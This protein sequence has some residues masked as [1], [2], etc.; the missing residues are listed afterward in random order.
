MKSLSSTQIEK[1]RKQ[2]VKFATL[3]LADKDLAEDVVQDAL[4][5]AYKHSA[6]FRREAALKTWIFAILKNKILDLLRTRKRHI[7]VSSLCE[8]EESPSAFF[9]RQ[10][11]WLE[12]QEVTEWRG[13]AQSTYRKE[14]WAIFDICLNKLSA[15]QARVFMMREH[16]DMSSAEICHECE[17]SLSNLNVLLYRARLRLQDCLSRNWFREESK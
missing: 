3:Q 8:E 9:D 11:H 10:D 5:N 1:I 12:H 7:P 15:Q 17:I 13:I 16:L 2:M 14:F 4:T 6:S